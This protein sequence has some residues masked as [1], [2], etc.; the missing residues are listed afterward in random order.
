MLASAAA[1]GATVV[2]VLPGHTVDEIADRGV[3]V[4]AVSGNG[5]A[6]E[7]KGAR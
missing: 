2:T 7:P 5:Q 3:S 1:C 4:L 6:I